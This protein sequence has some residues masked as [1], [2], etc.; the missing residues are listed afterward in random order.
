M[1]CN[2]HGEAQVMA[3][4]VMKG[5]PHGVGHADW[6]T[7]GLALIGVLALVS[8][9][10]HAA[11]ERLAVHPLV[12]PEVT[13]REEMEYRKLFYTEVARLQKN[14]ASAANVK[15][16]LAT[17]T[18]RT[19]VSSSD[20]NKCLADLARQTKSTS[21]LFV[22]LSLYPRLRLSGQ[23]VR[24]SGDV[25]ASAENDYGKPPKKNTR[26]TIRKWLHQFLATDLKVGVPDVPP[27]VVGTLPKEKPTDK[28][29]IQPLPG[30]SPPITL[31]PTPLPP[32]PPPPITV[33]P[34]AT[35]APAVSY[36]PEEGW[37]WQMTTGVALA[38]AGVVSLGVGTYYKVR[39]SNSWNQ[40]NNTAAGGYVTPTQISQLQ[41]IQ[42]QAQSQGRTGNILLIAGGVL[43]AGGAGLLAWE[44]A[45][46]KGQVMVSAAPIP[47]G[48]M[49]AGAFP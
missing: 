3:K 17:L 31:A 12:V 35:G 6:R 30:L 7:L 26:E 39:S 34:A 5:S 36:V 15:A 14:L 33:A 4:R 9:T 20:L 25:R 37:S 49:V 28:P 38:T 8:R 18:H 19:C 32:E 11:S 46:P 40:F 1:R 48:V 29:L 27:L 43:T 21:A 42:S 16:F 45:R 23:V 24:S 41:D 2:A 22:T 13:E 47:G 10:T 44:I